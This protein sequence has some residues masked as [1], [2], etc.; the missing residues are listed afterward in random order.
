MPQ[1][2]KKQAILPYYVMWMT[3]E[4]LNNSCVFLRKFKWSPSPLKLEGPHEVIFGYLPFF[5]KQATCT[6]IFSWIHLVKLCTTVTLS[7][8]EKN[9]TQIEHYMWKILALNLARTF[10]QHMEPP[11]KTSN[12]NLTKN[13]ACLEYEVFIYYFGPHANGQHPTLVDTFHPCRLPP[14]GSQ[15]HQ[16]IRWRPILGCMS[17]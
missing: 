10:G 11:P 4:L 16:N 8:G 14:S 1:S 6:L 3:I 7:W 17:T 5:M 13:H 9:P 15:T 12:A 2:F